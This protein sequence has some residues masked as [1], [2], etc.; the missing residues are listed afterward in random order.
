M[1]GKCS[2]PLR[3]MT[4]D[5]I[6]DYDIDEKV[7]RTRN[8][9][10]PRGAISP[11][12]AWLFFAIQ[13]VVGVYIAFTF[14]AEKS[15]RVSVAVWPLYVIYPTCKRWM[16]FAPIPLGLMFNVGVFM[17]WSD[18]NPT[19]D[20]DWDKLIPI[21]TGACLWTFT[22]ETVYQHQDK[23]DDAKLGIYSPALFFGSFTIPTCT[24]TA[25]SFI[26]LLYY[27]GH[28]NHQ[29]IS[30]YVVTTIAGARLLQT[31]VYTDVDRPNDCKNMFL[32]TPEIGR[33]ILFGFILDAVVNRL[34]NGIPL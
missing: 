15:L 25:A 34:I 4:I 22:Y 21:Y 14:L 27:G 28:C 31:L 24:M 9:C 11:Q 13:A 1:G 30:F 6:L 12:R 16:C 23:V 10:I 17:G 18:L 33:I 29:G 3:I 7:E 5:D 32:A 19:G 26:G 20:I 2:D 8:R